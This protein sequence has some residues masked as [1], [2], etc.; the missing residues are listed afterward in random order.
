MSL[1]ENNKAV[2]S[3]YF[4]E[5][6]GKLN[7]NIVDELCADD[8][9]IAYPMHGP[10]YG[11]AAAKKMLVDFKAAFPDLYFESYG[12]YGLIAEGDF[13][14]GRWIGGGT[15][16]GAA[17]D[18]LVLGTLDQPNTGRKMRFSGI[19]IFTLKNGKITKEIGEEGGMS[20]LQ[21]LGIL[22]PPNAGKKVFYDTEP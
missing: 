20:A 7:P 3:K 11:K 4:E 21:Q 2:V 15:H 1:Q 19:T 17:F 10:K 18:D 9:V 16:T 6:W 5:Y 8:F 13:V 22:P 12:D 14:A